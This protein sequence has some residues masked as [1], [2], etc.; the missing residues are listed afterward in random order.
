MI[1]NLPEGTPAEA[2]QEI[3]V[4]KLVAGKVKVHT[5]V[6]NAKG[7]I[8]YVVFKDPGSVNE[9]VDAVHH[10]MYQERKLDVAPLPKEYHMILAG[11]LK[12][13]EDAD[14]DKLPV[15]VAQLVLQLKAL[16]PGQIEEVT[17]ATSWLT[18]VK[19]EAPEPPGGLLAQ[20]SS[21]GL[22]NNTRLPFFSGDE[23]N[24]TEVTYEQWSCE[25]RSLEKTSVPSSL[26]LQ[27]ARRS[28]RG[29]AATI[30]LQLGDKATVT[31][32]L[33]KLDLFFGDVLT[34]EELY[35][36]FYVA[37]QAKGELVGTWALRVESLLSHLGK[38]D[39]SVFVPDTQ[40]NMLRNR[41]FHGCQADGVKE[42]IRHLHG[43]NATYHQLLS[44]ARAAELESGCKAR[45]QQET[46]TLE[47]TSPGG[48]PIDKNL[49]KKLD[50]ILESLSKVDDMAEKLT[51][52][53]ERIQAM[54]GRGGKKFYGNPNRKDGSHGNS[55][56][57]R[58]QQTT[59]QRPF[60]GN[61]FACGQPGHRQNECPGN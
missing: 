46:V 26:I 40:E 51:K 22:A 23:G 18:P 35:R 45:V 14:E 8:A 60:L 27:A 43:G 6:T 61:C 52:M 48:V 53:E 47:A 24:K 37:E 7:T 32:M 11:L 57:A 49:G 25:V 55:Q 28:L 33:Q 17:A 54:D 30:L 59:S 50:K 29:T 3:V 31:T 56:D 34:V 39:P 15:D 20:L 21:A 36:K 13:Q 10:L 1:K 19:Q 9:A 16:S 42:K 44:A 58:R 2:V 5:C 41:F 12:Q 38:K 4:D